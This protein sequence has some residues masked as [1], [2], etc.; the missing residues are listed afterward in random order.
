MLHHLPLSQCDPLGGAPTPVAL[1][2]SLRVTSI[3]RWVFTA[4]IAQENALQRST[5]IETMASLTE[6]IDTGLQRL[7][8]AKK[9]YLAGEANAT[10]AILDAAQA[11]LAAGRPDQSKPSAVLN[12]DHEKPSD[13]LQ[14]VMWAEVSGILMYIYLCNIDRPWVTEASYP[15]IASVICHR[16]HEYIIRDL[17][18]VPCSPSC[19][20]S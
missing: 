16:G 17:L 13:F 20:R 19:R 1:L 10:E 6:A 15:F 18:T 12:S 5:N 11:I 9:L 7:E 14:R 2:S 8:E 3:E 4:H